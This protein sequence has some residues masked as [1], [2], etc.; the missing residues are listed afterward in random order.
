M[1]DYNYYITKFDGK[2]IINADDFEL[3]VDI[4][5]RYVKNVVCDKAKD[6]D[7]H[8]AV[9][10]VCEYL[11]ENASVQGIKSESADG[12]SI[13]YENTDINKHLYGIIKLYIP[14]RL[15]YRGLNY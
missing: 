8:D 2:K 11:K 12:V 6:S 10:A 1:T 7:I 9:C 3:Y 4:A 14:S 15:L 5:Y 13:N